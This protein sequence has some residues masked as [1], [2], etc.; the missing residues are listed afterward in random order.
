MEGLAS[1]NPDLFK[2][3]LQLWTIYLHLQIYICG[4]LFA[5]PKIY[6]Q[7]QSLFATLIWIFA[8]LKYFFAEKGPVFATKN[9]ICKFELLI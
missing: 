4:D 1:A 7:L 9:N 5:S 3:Y 2:V 8:S 6:L